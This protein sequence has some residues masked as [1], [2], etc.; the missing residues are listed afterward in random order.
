M[1]LSFINPNHEKYMES[2]EKY[3]EL[4]KEYYD[5][6]VDI[7]ELNSESQK[8]I[9]ELN[10]NGYIYIIGDIIILFAYFGVF[11]YFKK[12]QTFGKKLLKIKIVSNNPEKELK[13]YNYFIRVF[14]LNSIILNISTLIAICFSEKIYVA[15]NTYASN[16]D[17]I[18]L[19]TIA[20]M[21]LFRKD[22]RGLHDVLSGTKV[23]DLKVLD[24][25][26]NNK[27]VEIIKPKRKTKKDEE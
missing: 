13:P 26:K 3:N 17:T 4:L 7:N 12:G 15:I 1:M 10:K 19:I 6:E 2:T 16:L 20:L 21:I 11:A 8:I 9:Y 25:E 27:K 24:E 18:I 5:D 22:G 23:V 14:I